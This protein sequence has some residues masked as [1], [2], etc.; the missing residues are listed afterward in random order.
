MYG[1]YKNSWKQLSDARVECMAKEFI[2]TELEFA[3]TCVKAAQTG[4]SMGNVA[5]GDFFRKNAEEAYHGAVN[6]FGQLS[7]FTS[8]ERWKLMDLVHQAKKA[9][10]TLPQPATH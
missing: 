1:Q 3:L 5:G 7:E 2:K 10:A 6:Y 4:Y 9:I 8:L